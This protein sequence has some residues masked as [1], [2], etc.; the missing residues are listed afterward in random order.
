M[1]GIELLQRVATPWLDRV[2]MIGTHVGSEAFFVA[3][4]SVTYL[5]IDAGAGRRLALAV[6]VSQWTNQALKGVVDAPR[7]FELDPSLLRLPGAAETAPHASFPSGHA[8]VSA[9]FWTFA[10][11]HVRRRRF[12]LLAVAG[13][14]GVAWTRPYLGV[15]T[16]PDVLAGVGIGVA[17][18]AGAV[19]LVALG[20]RLPSV[21]EGAL[22]VGVPLAGV[23]LVPTPDAA[24]LAGAFAGVATA[25]LLRRHAPRGGPLRRAAT[26]AAGLGAAAAVLAAGSAAARPLVAGG[27]PP[28]AVEAGVT[29][30]AVYGAWVAAPWTADALLGGGL[31]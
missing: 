12:G 27:V 1:T 28:A 22:G 16:V 3:A 6:V 17:I 23:L 14:V 8:Q 29:L 5:A 15:H 25:P 18:A 9:T 31:R 7:P 4:L 19:G 20:V 21:A 13:V 30:A 10:A 24:R 11:W 26:A 2:A